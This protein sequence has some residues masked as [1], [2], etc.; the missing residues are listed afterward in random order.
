M[1]TTAGSL[2]LLGSIRSR[3]AF[4]AKKLRDAGAV[5]LGKTNLSEWANIRSSVPAAA[6]VLAVGRRGI[7]MCLTAI[8]VDQVPVLALRRRR[9]SAPLQSALKPTARSFVP[10]PQTLW[11]ESNRRWDLSAGPALSPSLTARTLPDRWLE[12]SPTPRSCWAR[13]SGIDPRD[14]ATR[15]G[16]GKSRATTPGFSTRMACAARGSGSH[17]SIS[18]LMI[19]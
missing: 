15:A 10:H 7:R 5:I 9:T 12:R 4:V 13:S 17:E 3:D 1:M 2:A 11:L 14:D 18:A 6:G 16:R 19:M 8:P